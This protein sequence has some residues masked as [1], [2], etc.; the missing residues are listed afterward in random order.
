MKFSFTPIRF[1]NK[2]LVSGL[3]SR[4]GLFL[5]EHKF[6]T[7]QNNQVTQSSIFDSVQVI[8]LSRLAWVSQSAYYLTSSPLWLPSIPIAHR[9]L[10][11]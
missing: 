8:V 3:A 10:I 9:K 6:G 11:I 2:M 7:V 5:I 4:I 1:Y